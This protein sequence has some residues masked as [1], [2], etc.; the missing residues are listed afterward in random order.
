MT[1]VCGKQREKDND[2]EQ[3]RLRNG[4]REEQKATVKG[5]EEEM[6]GMVK[7]H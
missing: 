6:K 2:R 7:K 4:Q 5:S 1:K 3:R